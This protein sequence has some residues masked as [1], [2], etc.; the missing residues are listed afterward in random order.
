MLKST[1][2]LLSLLLVSGVSEGREKFKLLGKAPMGS[3]FRPVE[4]ESLIPFNKEYDQ[5]TPEQR[6]LYRSLFVGIKEN[7]TPPYPKHG[8]RKLYMPLIKGNERLARGGWLRLIANINEKGEVAEVSI[9]E[10]PHKEI[11][12]LALAVMFNVKFY[13]A[14]CDGKPCAMDFQF[15]YDIRKTVKQMNTLHSED[16]PGISN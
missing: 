10:S 15:E 8:T 9:Y 1:I 12:E 5:Y 11:N 13:P 7:E 6:S 14:T 16:I 3:N 4:V 2:L